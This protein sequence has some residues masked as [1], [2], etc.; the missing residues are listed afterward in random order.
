MNIDNTINDSITMIDG[1]E[2]AI[3]N[4]TIDNVANDIK[5]VLEILKGINEKVNPQ[6]KPIKCSCFSKLFK[7]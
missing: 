1:I 6:N 4:S 2:T 5:M 7:K 3:H